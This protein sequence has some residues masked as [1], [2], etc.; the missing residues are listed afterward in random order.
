[1][2]R[3]EQNCQNKPRDRILPHSTRKTRSHSLSLHTKNAIAFFLLDK[4]KWICKINYTLNAIES[5]M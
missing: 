3:L 1:M 2:T 5:L 4:Y